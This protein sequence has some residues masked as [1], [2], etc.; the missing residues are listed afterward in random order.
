MQQ[1]GTATPAAHTDASLV[2]RAAQRDRASVDELC[3]RH[4]SRLYALGYRLTGSHGRAVEF[5]ADA[6]ARTLTAADEIAR[7][8]LDF[9]TYAIVTAKALFLER[10]EGG[11]TAG[12]ARSSREAG[13]LWD[14][15]ESGSIARRQH[16][17]MRLAAVTLPPTQ[18]LVLALRELERMNCAEIA[19]LGELSEVEVAQTLADARE[20]LRVQLGLTEPKRAARPAA[21]AAVV[22]L[23]SRYV[24]GELGGGELEAVE[25]H[26]ESCEFCQPDLDDLQEISRRYRTFVPAT[27][28]D[29]LA[30]R[31][32]AA[33]V[34]AGFWKPAGSDGSRRRRVVALAAAATALA[35]AG[36]GLAYLLPG[37]GPALHVDL[38]A[39]PPPP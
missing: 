37:S 34:V 14:D 21:C 39:P 8:Q 27:P 35:L 32:E 6:F 31:V 23:L 12:R 36:I 9:A 11:Q 22:P 16:E 7:E 10:V 13:W 33:L 29:E 17:V 1:R 24:D 4:V 25:Q 18:R 15:S 2:R 20:R 28:H 38:P 30:E 3:A 26:L 5:A 19:A